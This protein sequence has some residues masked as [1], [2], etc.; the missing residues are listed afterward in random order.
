MVWGQ[1]ATRGIEDLVQRVTSNDPKLQSLTILRQRR[2]GHEDVAALAHALKDNTTLTELYASSHPLSLASVQLLAETLG[3]NRSLRSL[4]VGD[5]SLGDSGVEAL[6]RGVASSS[7]LTRLDLTGKGLGRRGAAALASALHSCSS[8]SH[9]VLNNNPQLGD[10]GFAAL[11][12][13]APSASAVGTACESAASAA[14]PGSGWAGSEIVL[15][16]QGCSVGAAGLAAAA[17]ASSNSG[18]LRELHLQ[19]NSLGLTGA[20][21]LCQLLQ[22]THH[23]QTLHLRGTE[24][25]DD[26]GE[27]L[28]SGL[29][30][31]ASA[32]G[33][34]SSSSGGSSALK[35][36]DA[37][38]CGLGPKTMAALS[39]AFSAG[40]SLQELVLAGNQA[41]A[42]AD[43]AH[44]GAA[45]V[46]AAGASSVGH[47]DLSGTQAGPLA[48]ESLSRVPGL[49]HVSLVGCPLAAAGGAALAA[50]LASSGGSSSGSWPA[51]EELCI[52]GTGLSI[53]DTS[54]VFAALAAG[55]APC[56]KS[57]E[58]GANPAAQD[59]A[60]LAQLDAL[61]S[62]RPGIAVFWRSGDD[63]AP[64]AQQ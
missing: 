11:F 63:P 28:A 12:T 34:G 3:S 30:A 37:A 39:K 64:G 51:L 18:R 47:L 54:T 17:Q 53:S 60:F 61:R 26:G 1:S 8:L 44:L 29:T 19:G 52:S 42:D 14:P 41:I 45:L 59:D 27:V 33:A 55:G 24:L 31:A 5:S 20:R 58:I 46:A 6:A 35:T 16:V 22:S 15:E 7:S 50:S 57:L 25:G 43:A 56:L 21:A 10:E 40:L 32:A 9:L 48:V 62:A 23:L 38:D 4:C 13:T 2:F 49:K 36:I